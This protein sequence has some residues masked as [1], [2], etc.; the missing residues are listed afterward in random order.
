MLGGYMLEI[1]QRVRYRGTDAGEVGVVV[2]TWTDEHGDINAYVAF[3]G[4]TFP[5]GIPERTPYVLRYYATT[6]EVI[7]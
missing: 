5:H 1:G 2:W 6:L 4:S 7:E 3:F